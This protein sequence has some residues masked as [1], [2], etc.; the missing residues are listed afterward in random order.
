MK[1]YFV[2]GIDTD[3]GKT[4]VAAILTEA[5][6][7]DYWKPIQAGELDNSDTMKV[8]NLISNTNTKFHPESYALQTP[9]SPHYAAALDK[10]T[11]TLDNIQPP[12]TN[13][14]LIIEG[15]GGLF[16]PLNKKLLIIDLIE[17]WQFP[18]VLVSKN[19][20]GSINHTLLS[21]DALQKRGIPIAGIIFNGPPTPS[22]EDFILEYTQVPKLGNLEWMDVVNKE[23]IIEKSKLFV[24]KI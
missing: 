6:K 16:V 14:H 21:I 20:L 17:Q 7:A 2:S 22:T 4:V 23:K 24:D 5:M 9:A 8:R 18:V 13:N 19:Y 1:T 15:A 12:K 3:A 11:I 10:V